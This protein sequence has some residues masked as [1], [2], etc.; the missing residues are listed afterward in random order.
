VLYTPKT[1]DKG[2]AKMLGMTEDQISEVLNGIDNIQTAVNEKVLLKFCVRASQKDNY[3]MLQSDVD[4]VREA[5]Y[6]DSEILEAVVTSRTDSEE[7]TR[8]I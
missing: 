7:L 4:E 8:P 3:K 6:S 5:G 1:Q 2:I